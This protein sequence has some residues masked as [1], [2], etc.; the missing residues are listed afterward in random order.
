VSIRFLQEA[1]RHLPTLQ[2]VRLLRVIHGNPGNRTA[3]TSQWPG[4]ISGAPGVR[5]T[6]ALEAD[7]SEEGLMRQRARLFAA[8][9]PRG[10]A[11]ISSAR[12]RT[13][14]DGC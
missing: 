14:S 8:S 6:A 11:E 5:Q 9:L 1:N 2:F 4:P 7:R 10:L 12:S 13:N 3:E